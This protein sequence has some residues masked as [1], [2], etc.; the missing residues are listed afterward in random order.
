MTDHYQVLGVDPS[1]SAEEIKKAYRKLARQFHP[2]V[3]PGAESG[4]RFKEI[5]HAY[6]V[7]SDPAQRQVYDRGGNDP[8]GGFGGFSGFGDAFTFFSSAASRGPRSR[9]E[10]GQDALIRVEVTLHDVMFGVQHD[11]EVDT[12]VV[13]ETCLGSCTQEGTVPV[14]CVVCRGAGSINRT[15]RSLLGD[16]VMPATCNAC[17]GYGTTIEAECLTC[18]GAGRVRARRTVSIQIPAGVES[19]MRLQMP[20]SGEVGPGGG[21]NG[22]LYVEINVAQE[23]VFLRDKNDL[24]CMLEV[25]LV[26]AILGKTLTLDALDGAVNLEIRAGVQ[27]GDVL[28]IKHRGIQALRGRSRGDLNVRIHVVIPTKLN[29]KQKKIIESFRETYKHDDPIFSAVHQSLFDKVRNFFNT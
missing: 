14:T 23:D 1:A 7:L 12:A 6:D 16:I 19:G 26:D 22:D 5:T 29:S 18:H 13:C 28:T 21:P 27:N 15:H 3:N 2:D 10:P 8:T 25:G 4:E 24:W 20:G 9:Q 17:Q 11:V